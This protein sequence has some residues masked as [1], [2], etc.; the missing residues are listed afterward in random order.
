[1]LLVRADPEL[2]RR[3]V[4]VEG[5]FTLEDAFW[6]SSV[7]RMSSSE[8][9]RMIAG[10]RDDPAGWLADSGIDADDAALAVASEWLANQ[11]ATTVKAMA[12][13]VIEVTAAPA[14]LRAVRKV[15]DRHT[16]HLVA[17]ERSADG[18]DVPVWAMERAAT[19]TVIPGTGHLVMLERTAE[20]ATLVRD[21]VAEPESA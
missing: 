19:F 5:N 10:F 15:F 1:M 21:L 9:D 7:A 17:G 16:V 14:Y 12:E 20:F 11:P 2:V 8:V 4:S 6:T 13:S 18:W 3:V